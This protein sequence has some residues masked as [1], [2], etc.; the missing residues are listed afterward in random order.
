MSNSTNKSIAD[1][2]AVKSH[3][4]EESSHPGHLDRE[5]GTGPA[6]RD[7]RARQLEVEVKQ[8]AK[9]K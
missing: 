9:K 5:P 7:N 2:E 8:R 4:V 3:H 6:A 1:H